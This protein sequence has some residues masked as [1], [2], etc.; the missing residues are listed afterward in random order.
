M[1]EDM[2]VLHITEAELARDM[3]AVLIKVQQGI[4][5]IVE[6]NAQP[7]AVMRAP[8]FRGRSIDECI[9]AVETHGSHTTLDDEFAR[10]LEDII[11]NHR[12]PLNPVEWD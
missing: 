8:A 12:E 3:Q 4:E 1:T 5:V 2:A 9:A 10:D 11:N 7:I 6:R